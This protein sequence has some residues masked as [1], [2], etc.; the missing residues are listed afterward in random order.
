MKIEDKIKELIVGALTK[1]QGMNNDEINEIGLELSRNKNNEYGDFSS[2]IALKLS[3]KLKHSPMVIAEE[4]ISSIQISDELERTEFVNPGFIN[5]YLSAEKKHSVLEEIISKEK[6]FGASCVSEKKKI[7][8]EFVSANPTGPLH[9]GHGRH[10]AF[11]DSLARLLRK[12]GH[13]VFTEYYL[14]DAGR[15]IDIL[16]A[17]VMFD[18]LLLEGQKLD[19]PVG[20]Y[21]GLYIKEIAEWLQNEGIAINKKLS[22]PKASRSDDDIIDALILEMKDIAGNDLFQIVLEKTVLQMTK[23]LKDD[24]SDFINMINK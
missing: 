7:L 3:G 19:K 10:A 6:A 23:L 20:L 8:L 17:S 18:L 11:G 22:T 5:F 15:Q 13:E 21:K 1:S 9:V 12:S 16:C 24:L 2:N 4:I 14:N